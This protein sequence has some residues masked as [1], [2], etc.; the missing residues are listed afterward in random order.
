[1]PTEVALMMT[2]K[3]GLGELHRGAW[4]WR[5]TGGRA[6]ARFRGAIEDEDFGALVATTKDGGA[7]CSAAGAEHKHLGVL[8]REAALQ[9]ADDAGDIRIEAVELAVGQRE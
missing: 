1:M 4:S 6:C 8:E 9:R 5:R 2:S 3:L 7:S